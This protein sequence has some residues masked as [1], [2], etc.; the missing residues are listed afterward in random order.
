[1]NLD[2][3]LVVHHSGFAGR[4]D[5]GK[6]WR[7]GAHLD[8]T[9]AAEI[10]RQQDGVQHGGARNDIDS[11]AGNLNHSD[12]YHQAGWIAKLCGGLYGRNEVQH[13]EVRAHS[14][15][16]GRQPISI[17]VADVAATKIACE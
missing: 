6:E 11:Q 9:R 15:R 4:K 7:T 12:S 1:M 13:V 3:V 17:A 14:W 10:A 5:H 2:E 8:G 16:G